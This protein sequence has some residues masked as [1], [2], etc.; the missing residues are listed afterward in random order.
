MSYSVDALVIGERP[1]L[2]VHRGNRGGVH[3][4]RVVQEHRDASWIENPVPTEFGEGFQGCGLF[5]S[6]ENTKSTG[7]ITT[8]PARTG[9]PTC[10]AE[11]LLGDRLAHPHTSVPGDCRLNSVDSIQ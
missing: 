3:L 2:L 5:P 9:C 6:C 8:S 1:H 10:C 11:D 4:W 7:L